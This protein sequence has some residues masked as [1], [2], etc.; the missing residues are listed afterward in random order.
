M[1]AL[2]Y[3]ACAAAC[4]LTF[5]CAVSL[6]AHAE[7][8]LDE[9][10]NLNQSTEKSYANFIRDIDDFAAYSGW[11][12]CGDNTVLS[13][14]A[15]KSWVNY[16]VEDASELY[17]ELYSDGGTFSTIANTGALQIGLTKME[18]FSNMYRCRYRRQQDK[19]YLFQGGQTY[20]LKCELNGLSF[21]QDSGNFD[22]DD[23]YYGAN[24]EISKD[25]LTYSTVQLKL[26]RVLWQNNENYGN[27]FREF[28]Y[29]TLPEGTNDVRLTLYGYNRLPGGCSD[30]P[31]YPKLS[32]V[33]ITRNEPSTSS[34]PQNENPSSSSAVSSAPES[35]APNNAD[36]HGDDDSAETKRLIRSKNA[37]I[38]HSY[39]EISLSVK[40]SNENSVQK[41]T[42][43][44]PAQTD[45]SSDASS[46][47]P[48]LAS[49]VPFS[50]QAS[51]Q[52]SEQNLQHFYQDK[53]EQADTTL[54]NF[55]MP[56]LML[57][58]IVSAIFFLKPR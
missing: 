34:E 57:L 30:L 13:M 29:A 8:Y 53:G 10:N 5:S 7:T 33:A 46:G 36:T 22:K 20:S 40:K 4:L 26:D 28:Y 25:G 39:G 43:Y 47:N 3:L 24:A 19:I 58:Q 15:N 50:E 12:S 44:F 49:S 37:E 9:C 52:E 45:H 51:F 35:A 31:N 2:N 38:S 6:K 32:R 18:Q 14:T 1:V 21:I 16:H 41:H 23:P 27:Y 11:G 48:R 17:V 54:Q 56:G 42:Q 55:L